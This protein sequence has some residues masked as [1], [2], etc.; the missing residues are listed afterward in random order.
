MNSI[1]PQTAGRSS[2]DDDV[3]AARTAGAELRRSYVAD[4]GTVARVRADVAALAER[5]G[6]GPERVADL[7]LIVSEAITNVVRHAYPDGPGALQV[8]AAVS[9]RHL[10]ILVSDD[11]VGPHALSRGRGPGWGW[12]LIAALTDSFTIRRRANGGTEVEMHVSIGPGPPTGCS[13]AARI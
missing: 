3:E 11:G 13:A 4:P 6:A 7:R 8:T 2:G 12:P 10:T 9:A 1:R 5:H